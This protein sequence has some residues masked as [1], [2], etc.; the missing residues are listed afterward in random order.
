MRA[1]GFSRYA[2]CAL[3]ATSL[4][5]GCGGSQPPIGANGMMLQSRTLAE[6]PR[7]NR[8]LY[9][10]GLDVS[11]SVVYVLSYPGGQ[12]ARKI[13]RAVSGLCT[14]PQGDVF[15]TQSWYS[16]SRILEYRHDGVKP[17]TQLMDPYTGIAG[18]AV[19]PTTGN[20]AVENSEDGTTLIYARAKGRPTVFHNFLLDAK[21]AT[22][23]DSGDLFTFG[24]MNRV[25][26]AELAR[27]A[28]SFVKI[29][30]P[31]RIGVPIGAQWDGKYLAVGDGVPYT[32]NNPIIYQ[33]TVQKHEAFEEGETQ[34]TN[35]ASAFFIDGKTMATSNG[36]EVD[37]YD[38]PGGGYP[39]STISD[40]NSAGPLAVSNAQ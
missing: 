11:Y 27:N 22:Y 33:L 2:V 14:D 3:T 9:V 23:D 12:P 31:R 34:I 20:L 4:L 10:A 16:A 29:K 15:M 17:V 36:Y 38:Y 8:L 18:C 19:D 37:I 39:A 21:Y 28:K 13:N 35:P 24:T 30:L 6:R 25:G 7:N 26:L 40:I 5:A 1:S 32:S